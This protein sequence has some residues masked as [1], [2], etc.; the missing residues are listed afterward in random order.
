MKPK[1]LATIAIWT[2][3]VGTIAFALVQV[4]TYAGLINNA[5]VI[6]GGT[7]QAVKL[8][9]ANEPNDAIVARVDGLLDKLHSEESAR[10]IEDPASKDFLEDIELVQGTWKF[11]KQE[12]K[13][14]D[15]GTGSDARLLALSEDHFKQADAMVMSAQRRAERDLLWT[16]IGCLILV[17]AVTSVVAF[18]EHRYQLARQTALET[19][20]L[21]DGYSLTGFERRARS[22][23]QASE[24]HAYL[25][26]YS[27]VESF[28]VINES[29]GRPAGDNAIRTLH[30]LL[31]RACTKGELVAHV[32]ADHFVMLIHNT[33]KRAEQLAAQTQARLKADE[34]LP[35]SDRI[36]CGYGVYE[37]AE[38][39]EDI[40]T[41]ISNA[42]AVLKGGVGGNLIA[43]YDEEFR[44]QLAFEQSVLRH[45]RDAIEREEF[46]PYLQSQTSL[47]DGSIVGAE[48]LCRWDSPE[49]GFLYP[50]RFIPQFERNGFISDLDFY[51]LEQACR[52]YTS[53]DAEG[54]RKPL[55]IAV[56]FSRVSLLENDFEERFVSLV[57]RYGMPPERLHFEVTEGVFSV[58]EDSV[59]A[60]LA[61]LQRRGFPIAMDDFGTGY[62][63]LSL[64]RKMPI[65][66]LKI[67]RGFLSASE[68]DAR[69]RRVLECVI[70]LANDL[71]IDTVCEG[72]ETAEQAMLL[73]KLG[74][75]IAQGYYFARPVP[76]DELAE[77]LHAQEPTDK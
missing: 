63:S 77:Q 33:D 53:L 9:L 70:N 64:L 67:D 29:F 8:A 18:R 20:P 17:I 52:R 44:S 56:N 49:L 40:A 36:T 19:D 54:Q 55:H 27:N 12:F 1:T 23:V 73:H 57:E 5:G 66:V 74:C 32:N 41:A 48:M 2:I 14:L 11:I 69:S 65:D 62:S 50:D 71:G 13:D 28:R 4:Q 47:T 24:P 75:N 58:D 72:I 3:C 7:Q 6:R 37:I 43:R 59:L 26:V 60:I 34:S 25:I 15:N 42:E 45:M 61:S 35:F 39:T 16:I 31:K 46:V 10:P 22:L 76:F 68:D 30:T 38:A 51:M 21:T